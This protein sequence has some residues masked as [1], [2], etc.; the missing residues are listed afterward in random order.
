MIAPIKVSS[1]IHVKDSC[2]CS[3][4]PKIFRR[5]KKELVDLPYISRPSSSKVIEVYRLYSREV[6]TNEIV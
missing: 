6:T 5:K 1:A 4:I 3:C 2:N